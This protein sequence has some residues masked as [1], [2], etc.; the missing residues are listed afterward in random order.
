MHRLFLLLIVALLARPAQAELSTFSFQQDGLR[1]HASVYVPEGLTGPAPLILVVHGVASSGYDFRR[2]SRH[3][4]ETLADEFGYVI[5]Y[6]SAF[7]L[8]WSF[9]KGIGAEQ[10]GTKR[11]DLAYLKRVIGEAEARAEIDPNRI[12]AIGFSQGAQMSYA[13][14]CANPGLIRAMGAVSMG[15]PE[16]LRDDCRN[17]L[18]DGVLLAHGT[19]DP[20]VPFE[21]GQVLSGPWAT[22]LLKG[23]DDTLRYALAQKHCG[24]P[25]L[26]RKYDEEDDGTS[27]TRRLWTNCDPG[28]AVE[29]YLIDG[30]GH[31]W[32]GESPFGPVNIVIGPTT[33]EIDGAAMAFS[34][35]SRF[36]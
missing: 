27:V 10:L 25:S 11:D 36:R 9:S 2:T 23:F 19:N 5:A 29:A 3:A 22:M 24:A 13:L 31:R 21:G 30:G 1:R 12:F 8:V 18:P 4:F 35:F 34:F 16:L 33:Q 7:Q 6:P 20:I 15:L 26:T 32:P 28:T 14:A 17:H